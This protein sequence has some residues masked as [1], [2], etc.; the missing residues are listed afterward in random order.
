MFVFFKLCH[1]LA[2]FVVLFRLKKRSMP[3]SSAVCFPFSWA[4]ALHKHQVLIVQ[5]SIF[6][7]CVLRL[8]SSKTLCALRKHV[9]ACFVCYIYCFVYLAC[10]FLARGCQGARN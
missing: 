8:H 10:I 2:C 1:V 9:K 4:R 3:Q 6:P 7:V 5:R